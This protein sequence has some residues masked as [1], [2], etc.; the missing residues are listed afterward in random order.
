[1]RWLYACALAALVFLPP[2]PVPSARAASPV[3]VVFGTSWDGPGHGLQDVLDAYLGSP[4]ALDA[5][6]GFVGAHAGDPDPWFWVGS[7][8]PA[9]LV[10]E[11]AGR[12]ATNELGWYR[13]TFTRPVLDGVDDGVIF[14]GA[15]SGG[16]SALVT[17]PSGTTK[18]GFYLDT[19]LTVGSASGT[20]DQVFFTNRMLNDAGPYGYAPVHAPFDGDV[21]ALVYDVSRWKGPNTWLVCF[22]DTD[23]G[24]PVQACCNGTDNDFND[25]VFQVTAFGASPV[26]LVS[27]GALKA[28]YR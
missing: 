14:T 16:T 9:L 25:L 8:F 27:F 10:T 5:Q 6:T 1:M 11:V 24:L 4:G 18:F 23:S 17:F 20:H 3:P 21:Q 2:G 7:G 12:A 22:E 13:E 26:R 19:H 15:E 28:L